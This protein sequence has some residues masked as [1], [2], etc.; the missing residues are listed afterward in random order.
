MSFMSILI[1]GPVI[2]PLFVVPWLFTCPKNMVEAC[3]SGA[4]VRKMSSNCCVWRTVSVKQ[5]HLKKKN[6]YQINVQSFRLIGDMH[7]NIHIIFETILEIFF[8]GRVQI[9]GGGECTPLHPR[10]YVPEFIAPLQC[11]AGL[12]FH[13]E[14]CTEITLTSWPFLNL[15]RMCDPPA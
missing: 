15:P 5:I 10:S 2:S 14:L 13:A 8:G 9:W 1:H 4:C 11:F 7:G 12:I 3:Y 6:L